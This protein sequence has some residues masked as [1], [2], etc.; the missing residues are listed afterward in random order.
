MDRD[1]WE[2]ALRPVLVGTLSDGVFALSVFYSFRGN[3]E[4]EASPVGEVFY[5]AVSIRAVKPKL[6]GSVDLG[7]CLYAEA[8]AHGEHGA[9]AQE[10]AGHLSDGGPENGPAHR[11]L[12]RCRP[13]GGDPFKYSGDSIGNGVPDDAADD[14]T[15]G[16]ADF[17]A[18]DRQDGQYA[19]ID[20]AEDEIGSEFAQFDPERK[21]GNETEAT[22]A[23][24]DRSEQGFVLDEGRTRGEGDD[25]EREDIENGGDERRPRSS[26]DFFHP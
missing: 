9:G 22:E 13:F 8:V 26:V 21:E 15:Y 10:A 11:G 4:I 7:V 2:W 25:A 3:A 19:V 17:A 20:G 16:P 23:E 12:G 14:R 1:G 6:F 5:K 24:D 18:E